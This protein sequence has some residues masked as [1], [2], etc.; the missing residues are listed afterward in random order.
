MLLA[1]K[2]LQNMQNL[3]RGFLLDDKEQFVYKTRRY[4]KKFMGAASQNFNIFT[5]EITKCTSELFRFFTISKSVLS[6]RYKMHFFTIIKIQ[7][8]QLLVILGD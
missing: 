5:L 8:L 6:G 3:D 1:D 4:H 7:M 2:T